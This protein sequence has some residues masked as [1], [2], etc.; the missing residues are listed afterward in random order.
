MLLMQGLDG[1][2][3]KCSY[4]QQQYHIPKHNLILGE[5]MLVK[6]LQNLNIKV[7]NDPSNNTPAQYKVAK[8]E[9]EKLNNGLERQNNK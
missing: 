8:S 4:A 6:E 7:A 3:L 2:W 9:L 5:S 1:I